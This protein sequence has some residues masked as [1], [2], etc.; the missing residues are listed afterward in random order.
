MSKKNL[1]T[2]DELRALVMYSVGKQEPQMK[3][4]FENESITETKVNALIQDQ[5]QKLAG[6]R[7]DFLDNE[8]LIFRLMQDAIDEVLPKRVFDSINIFAE[9]RTVK[10]GKKVTFKQPTGRIRG[11]NFITRVAHAGTYEVFQMDRK[12]WD[13]P[14]TAYGGAVKIQFEEMLEGRIDFPELI[15]AVTEGYEEAIYREILLQLLSLHTGTILPKANVKVANGF[16][17]VGFGNLISITRAY[18]TPTIFCSEVFATQVLPQ[19]HM[20]TDSQKETHA[21]QGYLGSY[22]NANI[23]VLPYSFYDTSNEA[24]ALTLP[25]GLAWILPSGAGLDTKPVKVVF[26]GETYL[27]NTDTMDWGKKI[28]AYKKMGIMLM[29]NPGMT[30]YHNT[31]LDAWPDIQ[32]PIINMPNGEV[33]DIKYTRP[34]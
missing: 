14:V 17:P 9:F 27:K 12:I 6:N 4:L 30:V 8:R 34:V 13:M 11:R 3:T 5:F 33:T 23:V 18:G 1:L 28:D 7:D 31:A 25:P 24:A 32:G 20:I 19:Q 21:S 10:N 29:S 16:A 26:E 15:Q 2:K 22:Q